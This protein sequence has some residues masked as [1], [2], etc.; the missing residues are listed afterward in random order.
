MHKIGKNFSDKI[1]YK[2]NK[3]GGDLIVTKIKQLYVTRVLTYLKNMKKII[4]VLCVFMTI[5]VLAIEDKDILPINLNVYPKSIHIGDICFMKF[6]VTNE[7]NKNLFLTYG[8]S[9]DS[10]IVEFG[11]LQEKTKIGTLH[12]RDEFDEKGYGSPPY[13]SVYYGHIGQLVKSGKILDFYFHGSWIPI[14]GRI[15]NKKLKENLGNRSRLYFGIVFT[16]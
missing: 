8:K 3:F 11:L 9:I 16:L 7:S 13:A 5:P 12:L 4:T 14:P 2:Y 10:G 1:T 6:T 15:Q